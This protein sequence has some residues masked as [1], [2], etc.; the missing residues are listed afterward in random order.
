MQV[1]KTAPASTVSHALYPVGQHLKT[2]L[3][4]ELLSSTDT[5]S[6]L[7]FTRTKHRAKKLADQLSKSGYKATSLQGNLSQNARQA[8]LDGFRDG[9]YQILVATDIAARGIDVS[10]IA[11]VINYDMPDTAE[12][13]THRIGRTGRAAK[14]GDAYSL[15]TPEDTPILRAIE[16]LLGTRPETRKLHDFDYTVP[17]PIR[18]SAPARPP[19][20]QA[21]FHEKP[22]GK[23]KV[24]RTSATR[25]YPGPRSETRSSERPEHRAGHP[26]GRW[27]R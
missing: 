7:V 1:G 23:A 2:Q 4:V 22:A 10:T 8:A 14:T 24:T 11:H 5:D 26:G 6:V 17:A 3:L 9:S 16:R 19:R 21:R 13:Y 15:V 12:T 27:A 25:P 18:E 20:G